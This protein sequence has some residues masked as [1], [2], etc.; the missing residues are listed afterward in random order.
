MSR[1]VY[2]HE[3]VDAETSAKYFFHFSPLLLKIGCWNKREKRQFFVK[4]SNV[5]QISEN[6]CYIYNL[7]YFSVYT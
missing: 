4:V 1:F 7:L 3:T 5:V 6:Y 2:V